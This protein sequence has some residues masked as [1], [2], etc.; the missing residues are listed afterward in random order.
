MR[1]VLVTHGSEGDSRPLLI[2]GW[3]LQR[4]GHQV[5]VLADEHAATTAEKMGLEFHALAGSMRHTLAGD[6]SAMRRVMDTGRMRLAAL[7]ELTGGHQDWIDQIDAAVRHADVVVGASL[8]G[9][10]ALAVADLRGVPSLAVGYHPYIRTQEFAHPLSGMTRTAPWMNRPIGTTVSIMMWTAYEV[11]FNR[12]RRS[13]D[14]MRLRQP[15]EDHP[16]LGA[17]SPTLVPTPTDWPAGVTVTGDWAAGA[18]HPELGWAD[19]KPERCLA[20]FLAEGEPPIYVGFGSMTGF[21]DRMR[22]RDAVLEAFAGRRVLLS[23]GWA[24]LATGHLP[25]GVLA[26]GAVPHAWL[27]P[28]CATVVHHCGAG[29]AHTAARAGVPTIP[30][31]F[32]ADQPFWADRLRR[33]GVA[34]RPL[35]RRRVTAEALTAAYAEVSCPDVRERAAEISARMAGEDGVAAAVAMIEEYAGGR[36]SPSG[37]LFG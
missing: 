35:R 23:G 6:G 31:P 13:L 15:P 21:G 1:A 36:A 26:I 33:L 8:A 29:T 20:E 16:G 34:S 25:E 32:T 27:F 4:A 24:D 9:P 22:L 3:E 2:L 28:R 17:W 37:Q 5:V 7:R 30:V 14:G 18:H 12:G 10:Q 19:W 11:S